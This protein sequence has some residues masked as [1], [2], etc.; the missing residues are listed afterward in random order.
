MRP[1]SGMPLDSS[2]H[3]QLIHSIGTLG[4][5]VSVSLETLSRMVHSLENFSVHVDH[6]ADSNHLFWQS[7]RQIQEILARASVHL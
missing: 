4:I 5:G 3:W 6:S 7:A 2:V 1:E